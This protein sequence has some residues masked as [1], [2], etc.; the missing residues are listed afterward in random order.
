MARHKHA[1]LMIAYANDPSIKIQWR[2]Q[3]TERLDAG[4]APVKWEDLG[5]Q[6]SFKE[7]FEYR[8]KPPDPVVV[9]DYGIAN[10]LVGNRASVCCKGASDYTPTN[11]NIKLTF[12]DGK[13]TG[14][15]VV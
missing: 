9:T 5:M 12:T 1:D 7:Y 3:I 10:L 6:P 2:G 13:L 8:I 15:E 4:F 14:T 11:C